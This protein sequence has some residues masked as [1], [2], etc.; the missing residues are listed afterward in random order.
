MPETRKA[1]D[2]IRTPLEKIL[3]SYTHSAGTDPGCTIR[4]LMTELMHLCD[5]SR[6]SF[7]ALLRAAREV[8]HQECAERRR[9]S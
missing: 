2:D 1:K 7:V 4:D 5:G 3:R 6:L 8:Y 9:S